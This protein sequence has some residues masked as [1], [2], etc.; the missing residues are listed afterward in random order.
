[1]FDWL[2]NAQYTLTPIYI[3]GVYMFGFW[4]YAFLSKRQ[5]R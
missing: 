1:M 4:T 3:A 2:Y 5:K